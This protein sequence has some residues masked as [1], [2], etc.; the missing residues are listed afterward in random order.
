MLSLGAINKNTGNYV[1]PKIANKKD[2]YICPECN[3]ELILC[4]GEVRVPYFR[5][6]F[7]V[8][9]CH[10]YTNP[11]ESQIHKDAKMLL[12]TLLEGKTPIQFERECSS[13][14]KETDIILPEVEQESI[15]SLEHRFSYNGSTKIADVA[16]LLNGEVKSIFEIMHTHKTS[17]E[18]R[19]E[20]W[21]EIDAS[22]LLN[23][24][25]TNEDSLKLKCI[26]G[27][28]CEECID[29]KYKFLNKKLS[30]FKKWDDKDIEF[31]IRYKLG[32]RI[33]TDKNW[34]GQP[35]K[36][37]NLHC[38]CGE[39]SYCMCKDGKRLSNCEMNQ[40]CKNDEIIHLFQD[41]FP[42]IEQSKKL[43]SNGWKGGISVQ[44]INKSDKH[45]DYIGYNPKQGYII[46]NGSGEGTVEIIKLLI[47]KMYEVVKTFSI[48]KEPSIQPE[49][50]T[51]S[52]VPQIKNSW[53]PLTLD[54]SRPYYDPTKGI[55]EEFVFFDI[56]CQ[57][58]R[59]VLAH[60]IY[61]ESEINGNPEGLLELLRID[62]HGES[63][64]TE[65]KEEM[66]DSHDKDKV[67]NFLDLQFLALNKLYT[68]K[69]NTTQNSQYFFCS[70]Y[71]YMKHFN[72]DRTFDYD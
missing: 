54:K 8:N 66:P 12:K 29:Q 20:P 2:D 55:P 61:I 5:H 67:T 4:Q 63:L 48:H 37:L 58:Y 23:Y 6:K 33:F 21:V 13:C 16:H 26:R 59:D 35:H 24:V 19:P 42:K 18:N 57:K 28:K 7:D 30:S 72:L 39:S 51:F 49:P 45:T 70:K 69:K 46:L 71:L 40:N 62:R 3:K 32:Q 31:Y 36:R 9:P 52:S 68:N 11:T 10:H 22:W 53:P 27:Y 14:K 44:L 15:I 34:S 50:K 65:I 43:I 56:L 38:R 17:S 64:L 60:V 25:N 41:L 47:N 1:Y